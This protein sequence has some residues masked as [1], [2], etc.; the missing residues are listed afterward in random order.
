MYR[1]PVSPRAGVALLA[2]TLAACTD[3][4]P[5]APTPQPQPVVLSALTCSVEVRAQSMSCRPMS[6]PSTGAHL[7]VNYGG[8]NTYVKLTSSGTSYDG[9]AQIFQTNVTVQNL[10]HVKVGTSDGS[11]VSGV[12]VV[13]TQ[14]GLVVTGGSGSATIANE[15]GTGTFTQAAQD[16]YNY[17]QILDPY[18]ISNSR[19]WQFAVD[20]TV[21]SF[22]FTVFIS[23][24]LQNETGGVVDKF[25][26]IWTGAS[27]SDWAMAANWQ[28]GV[29][30]DS[31]KGARVDST[32]T[33]PVLTAD[34]VVNHLRVASGTSLAE[35]GFTVTAW[36]NVDAVGSITGGTLWMRGTGTVLS[37]NVNA[38][39]LSGST[40]LQRAT[41]ATGAV[42]VTGT[43]TTNG[44]A[45]T[46]SIP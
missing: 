17:N 38:L 19:N 31:A 9:G 4:N 3:S 6:P 8:Q 37:G 11:T 2:L 22:T 7:D 33:A 15:D 35:A 20:N 32:A 13:F 26:A 29:V 16:Y 46:I 21:T 43:L 30:P 5:L 14:D 39:Q 1:L 25:D 45:L 28:N 36:G 41:T 42:S 18:Q 40:T 12:K 27:T 24:A 34:A 10:L 23:A 44:N